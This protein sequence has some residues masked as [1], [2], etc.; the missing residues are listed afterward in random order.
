MNLQS[1]M[2]F[3]P[4]LSLLYLA[5]A[6]LQA[7]RRQR[8][9]WGAVVLALIALAAPTAALFSTQDAALRS[10]LMSALALNA[11]IVFAT[12]LVIMLIE[13]R[14]SQTSRSY[15][16]LGI[17]LGVLLAAGAFIFPFVSSSSASSTTPAASTADSAALPGAMLQPVSNIT[18]N[19][20]AETTAVAAVLAEHTGLSSDALLAE[21]QSG[22][23]IARLVAAYGGNLE[24]VISAIAGALDELRGQDGMPAQMLAN[25]GTD[26]TATATQFVNGEL[27]SRAQQFLLMMLVGGSSG[28]MPGGQPRTQ[29]GTPNAPGGFMPPAGDGT[30]NAPGGFMPPAGGDPGNAN[31]T[32]IEPTV[33]PSEVSAAATAVT[34]R[35]TL[36]VFP[37]ASPTPVATETPTATVEAAASCNLTINYNLNLRAAP[38]TDSAVLL[39]IPYGSTVL[40]S[41]RNAEGWYQ[42][43]Y[44]GQTGWV[45]GDYV[46]P[47][48]G[49]AALPEA[50]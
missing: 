22:S 30:P 29:D 21:V 10:D 45:S 48:S 36:I 43:T 31:Q 18:A 24:A 12:S 7:L 47:A 35:P 44:S 46:T 4:F 19:T 16:M 50:P 5:F 11:V 14:R 28:F 49:C 1:L 15:G 17:G 2:A 27:D 37:T 3:A 41:R 26:S 34:I 32:V 9:G 6:L 20:A 40:A 42:V 23:T 25:L 38:N 8:Q 13:K 33:Q 39:S